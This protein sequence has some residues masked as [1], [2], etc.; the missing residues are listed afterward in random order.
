MLAPIFAV[1]A[2]ILLVLALL[3]LGGLIYGPWFTYLIGAAICAIVAVV[4]GRGTNRY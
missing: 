3:A 4:A 1:F 2:A